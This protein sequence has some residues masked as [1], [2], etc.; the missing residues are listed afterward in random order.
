MVLEEATVA[1]L[2]DLH[3]LI[4]RAYRGDFARV[5]WTHEADLLAGQ[6]TDLE[7]LAD[8]QAN[9]AQRL[10]IWRTDGV[11]AAAVALT[12]KDAALSYI[13]MVTVSPDRQGAGIGRRLLAA[14]EEHACASGAARIEMQVIRQRAEL[15]AWY[16]RRGYRETGERR[17]FP[18]GNPRAGQPKQDDLE[19][20]VLE[21]RL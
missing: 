12:R 20:L 14:A 16:R 6:R 13:G 3:A 4:E 17:P 15:L 18:Y 1:D 2:S 9:P 19:F 21:K 7:D 10:L 11:I 5:G 8:M